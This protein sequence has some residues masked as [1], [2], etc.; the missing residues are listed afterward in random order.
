MEQIEGPRQALS[1]DGGLHRVAL[2]RARSRAAASYA[3][4]RAWDVRVSASQQSGESG[5]AQKTGQAPQPVIAAIILC[6]VLRQR[7][8]Y[9]RWYRR[10]G[11]GCVGD[12]SATEQQRQG[13]HANN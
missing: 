1:T 10:T 4:A 2:L 5:Q 3:A 9:R 11:H 13:S 12:T 8:C 6:V 7:R